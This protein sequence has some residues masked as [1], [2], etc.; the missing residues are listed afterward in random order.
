MSAVPNDGPRT[1][2]YSRL[3]STA[4]SRHATRITA[5][6]A[7]AGALGNEVIKNLALLGIRG[8]C[9]A[10]RDRIDASNLTRSILYCTKDVDEEIA[11]GTPKALFAA[12][13]ARE[14][15][16]DVDVS[17]YVGEIA[18]L[19]A[20]ILRRADVVFSCLD[21]EMARLELSWWCTRLD[22]PLVDGGLGLQNASSGMVSIF[23][24]A[25]GPCYACRKSGERRRELLRDLHGREDP[26]WRKQSDDVIATTPLMAS[27]VGAMQVEF[28]VRFASNRV[29]ADEGRA[30]EIALH[31]KP[32]L[33]TFSFGRSDACPLHD[34]VSMI[35][36][37]VERVDRRSA[38]WTV[39][40]LLAES[41]SSDASL[42]LDWPLTARA[43][44]HGCSHEWEPLMRRARFRGERCPQCGGG[45]LVELE[46]LS[47]IGRSSPW[48]SRTLAA[49]GLPKGHI[50]EIA[51]G[52]SDAAPRSHVEIT[53]DLELATVA[54]C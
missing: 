1:R 6:V 3:E 13:R 12:R 34:P 38:D 44:C 32:R 16:R 9:I 54:A 51:C 5:V 33:D 8:L 40:D 22:K 46:V 39:L 28:G 36:S 53:G 10:D 19:G 14:I 43:R 15:N 47:E 45:E 37:V 52:S 48:A 18:D 49:L 17:A 35:T 42:V 21:N 20:A 30:W 29:R 11:L 50:H 41:G 4:F 31:P 25:S 24:G 27:V 2:D 26:C 23:P 7:G